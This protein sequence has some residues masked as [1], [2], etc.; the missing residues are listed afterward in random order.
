[1][2]R[3]QQLF[4]GLQLLL[5]LGVHLAVAGGH[6]DSGS[7]AGR[8]VEDVAD[9]S[10][11]AGSAAAAQAACDKNDLEYYLG[12]HAEMEKCYRGVYAKR[13]RGVPSP[14]EGSVGGSAPS[15]SHPCSKVDELY[16]CRA[17]FGRNVS[18]VTGMTDSGTYEQASVETDISTVHSPRSMHL[19]SYFKPRVR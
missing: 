9:G 16:K 5:L 6:V 14:S 2:R 18:C 11:V 1:M 19:A 12:K 15:A 17:Q 3:Q 4:G 10:D 13:R 7:V 8:I